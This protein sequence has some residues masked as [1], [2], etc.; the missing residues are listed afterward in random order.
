MKCKIH[1]VG[2]LVIRFCP[3][4]EFDESSICIKTEEYNQVGAD[5]ISENIVRIQWHLSS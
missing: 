2:I 3:I 1:H 4:D 5:K